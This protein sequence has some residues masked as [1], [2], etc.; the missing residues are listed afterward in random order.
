MQHIFTS[1]YFDLNTTSALLYKFLPHGDDVTCEK[2]ANNDF[3]LRYYVGHHGKFGHEFLEFE[4]RPD[5]KQ[6]SAHLSVIFFNPLYSVSI[7]KPSVAFFP[8]RVACSFH[9]VV[10]CS[11]R[12]AA[13]CEQLELQKGQH[14][15]EGGK[16][17]LELGQ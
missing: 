14:D 16:H 13:L 11:S 6:Q 8:P 1:K 2:M 4:F 9:L 17:D 15:Q 5:G 7:E 12:E 10:V 3:Y